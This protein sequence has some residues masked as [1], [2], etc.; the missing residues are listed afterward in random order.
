MPLPNAPT[1]RPNNPTTRKADKQA[2]NDLIIKSVLCLLFGLGV[3]L[4]P[5]YIASPDMQVIVA[6]A[7]LVGWLALVLGGAFLALYIRRRMAV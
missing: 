7:S 3:L 2:G 1:R 5:Y 4:S 6:K